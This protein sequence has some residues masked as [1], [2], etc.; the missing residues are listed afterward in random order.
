VAE[1]YLPAGRQW[2]RWSGTRTIVVRDGNRVTFHTGSAELF[3][4]YIAEGYFS[5][6]ALNFGDTIALDHA[7]RAALGRNRSYQ[8][9]QVIPYGVGT[10]VIWRY[11]PRQARQPGGYQPFPHPPARVHHRGQR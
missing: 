4:Q 5:Y 9:V 6:V 10:Y 3:G 2:W 11:R 1:Y 7:I 8:I